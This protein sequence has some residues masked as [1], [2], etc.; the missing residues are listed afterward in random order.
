MT[1]IYASRHNK[2]PEERSKENIHFSDRVQAKLIW[3]LLR[4]LKPYDLLREA[5]GE[6][7]V[8]RM[9]QAL[10]V[11]KPP[12]SYTTEPSTV[13]SGIKARFIDRVEGGD[14]ATTSAMDKVEGLR[15]LLF[16][17]A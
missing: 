15:K 6:H 1:I 2:F 7:N 17:K 5:M 8:E 13:C 3:G 9:R 14:E 11:Q 12:K 4:G 16:D 10:E